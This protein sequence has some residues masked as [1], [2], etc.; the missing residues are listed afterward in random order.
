MHSVFNEGGQLISMI[1]G[2]GNDE[3][4]EGSCSPVSS[5]TGLITG[6]L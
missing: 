1:V 2:V 5:S 3:E 6:A 4:A